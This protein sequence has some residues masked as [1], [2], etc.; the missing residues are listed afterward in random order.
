MSSKKKYYACAA[1]NG[2]IYDTWQKCK[3]KTHGKSY[4]FKGFNTLDDARKWLADRGYNTPEL[5]EREIKHNNTGS[6]QTSDLYTVYTDGGCDVNPGGRGGYGIVILHGDDHPVKAKGGFRCTTNNRMELMA[7]IKGLQMIP[8]GSSVKVISDSQYLVKTMNGVWK[9]GKNFD[10]WNELR[11]CIRNKEKVQFQWVR[12]HN[13]NKYNEICDSLATEGMQTATEPDTGYLDGSSAKSWKGN[14]IPKEMPVP[15]EIAALSNTNI[16]P[17]YLNAQ[18]I[19]SI[20][21][22]HK[23]PKH[24]F[25]SYLALKTGGQDGFSALK[26]DVLVDVV[27][28]DR[29]TSF[30]SEILPP[31]QAESASRWYLRGLSV[32]E[33][34]QKVLVDMEVAQNATRSQYPKR[35]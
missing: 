23:E 5:P 10:L 25:Q 1:E 8:D 15:E 16:P 27:R 33:A 20:E 7:A 29:I 21:T 6:G 13:G 4:E 24:S 22:F 14:G 3:D 28:D 31:K 30:F 35:F 2:I 19:A 9:E 17:A 26:G 18:G 34:Y 12:G 32:E 11:K